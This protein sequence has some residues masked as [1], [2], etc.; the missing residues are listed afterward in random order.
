[1]KCKNQLCI[2][3]KDCVCIL[4][5]VNLNSFGACESSESISFPKDFLEERK[6]NRLKELSDAWKDLEI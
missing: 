6:T 3:N 4:D 1:M 2:Y 5:E